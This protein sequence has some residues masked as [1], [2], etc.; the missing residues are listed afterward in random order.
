MIE[1]HSSPADMARLRSAQD[2]SEVHAEC[3]LE[4]TDLFSMEV[5][6]FVTVGYGDCEEVIVCASVRCQSVQCSLQLSTTW[7][8]KEQ[9]DSIF[10]RPA[11]H[12]TYKQTF[13]VTLEKR[14]H[15][16]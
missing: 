15:E 9:Q 5:S 1:I 6:V 3:V 4:I 12:H 16:K 2:F 10:K 7:G 13:A 11:L 14:V 8:L